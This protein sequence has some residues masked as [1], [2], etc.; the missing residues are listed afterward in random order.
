MRTSKEVFAAILEL[1]DEQG[2]SISELSRRVG[3]NKSTISRYRSGERPFAMGDV[4][5][6]AKALNVDVLSLLFGTGAKRKEIDVTDALDHNAK[7]I[8]NGREVDRDSIDIFKR[9]INK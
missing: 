3:V 5:K 1:M 7:M 9:I 2:M 8:Y 6:Y 4:D